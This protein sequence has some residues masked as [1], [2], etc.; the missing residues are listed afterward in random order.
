MWWN[1]GAWGAGDWIAM[2]FMMLVFWGLLAALT[3][4][5]VRSPRKRQ[6]SALLQATPPA[7]SRPDPRVHP[8]NSGGSDAGARVRR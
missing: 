6:D 7:T 3:V 5:L 4:W 8:S 2:S 1:N